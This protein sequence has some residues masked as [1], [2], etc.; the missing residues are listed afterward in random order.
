[1][2]AR[3][4]KGHNGPKRPKRTRATPGAKIVPRQRITGVEVVDAP[5]SR[6]HQNRDLVGM[7][8]TTM[9]ILVMLA[10]SIYAQG[11]T[12]GL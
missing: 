2:A 4:K 5:E 1:M 7:G 9:G 3:T 12:Q 11:T 6:E 10:L 8:A